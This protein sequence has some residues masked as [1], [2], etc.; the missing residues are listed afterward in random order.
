[1]DV[2]VS[3][4]C[5]CVALCVRR[6]LN[7]GLITRSRSPT[8]CVKNITKLKKR[9]RKRERG[10]GLTKDCRAFDEGMKLSIQIKYRVEGLNFYVKWWS[11][12]IF[13]A[14]IATWFS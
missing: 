5:V 12:N 1:M 9:E 6:G 13:S 8:I 11:M 10:A 4:F 2:C 7:D 3:L 14:L